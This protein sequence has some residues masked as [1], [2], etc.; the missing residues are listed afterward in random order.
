ME[1][2]LI[3]LLVL[4]LLVGTYF[5]NAKYFK[6][7]KAGVILETAINAQAVETINKL[8]VIRIK[9]E[10]DYTFNEEE[11]SKKLVREYGARLKESG[12][13]EEVVLLHVENLI[14]KHYKI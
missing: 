2:F 11:L 6:S 4:A 3:S 7:K 14:K 1:E 12:L 9:E 8:M 5:I 10:Q 13:T